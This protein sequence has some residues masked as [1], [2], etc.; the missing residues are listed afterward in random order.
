MEVVVTCKSP[1]KSL[2][3]TNQHKVFFYRPDALP[4]A[5]LTMTVLNV[6]SRHIYFESH[7][8]LLFNC[9]YVLIVFMYSH[10]ARRRWPNYFVKGAIE[11]P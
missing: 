6:N 9:F 2:P 8:N 1:V 10:I 3:P 11:V 4:V 5:Q 7:T